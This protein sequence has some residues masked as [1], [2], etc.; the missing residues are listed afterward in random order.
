MKG[1]E[2]PSL[3]PAKDGRVTEL[4]V[5]LQT[6]KDFG[7]SP[8]EYFVD[9]QAEWGDYPHLKLVMFAF[10]L[11]INEEETRRSKDMEKNTKKR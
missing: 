4:F 2:P 9:K 10:R 6:C 7:I 8:L 3:N 11:L 5:H 1:D